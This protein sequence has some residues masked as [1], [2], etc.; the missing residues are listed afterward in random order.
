LNNENIGKVFCKTLQDIERY[1][2][3]VDMENF[4]KKLL[5]PTHRVVSFGNKFDG[6]G[7]REIESGVLNNKLFIKGIILDLDVVVD[8]QRFL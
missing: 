7:K 4:C 2:V 1:G 8:A 5:Q 6:G 3:Y